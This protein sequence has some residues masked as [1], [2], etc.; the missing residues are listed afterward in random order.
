LTVSSH[1]PS[2]IVQNSSVTF[3]GTVDGNVSFVEVTVGSNVYTDNTI[4]N[5]VWSVDIVLPTQ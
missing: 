2:Q 3:S 1:T 4:V 5:G